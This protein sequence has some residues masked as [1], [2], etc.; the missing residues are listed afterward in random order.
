MEDKSWCQR[1]E[2][3]APKACRGFPYLVMKDLC[4]LLSRYLLEDVCFGF[5]LCFCYKRMPVGVRM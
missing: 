2:V 1:G 5:V 4:S 3:L